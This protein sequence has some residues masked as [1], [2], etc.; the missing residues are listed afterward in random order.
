M[1]GKEN[2]KGKGRIGKNRQ[3]LIA[4]FAYLFCSGMETRVLC[5]LGEYSTTELP[6]KPH[7][8]KFS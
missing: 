7:L 4:C 1:E 8:L 3:V 2:R 5:L 6:P